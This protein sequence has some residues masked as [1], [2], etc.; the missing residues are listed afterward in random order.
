MGSLRLSAGLVSKPSL[1]RHA[2]CIVVG[3]DK[4]PGDLLPP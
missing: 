3:N 1:I 4:T 2:D